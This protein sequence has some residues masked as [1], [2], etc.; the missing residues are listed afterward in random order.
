MTTWYCGECGYEFDASP[1][2]DEES[3]PECGTILYNDSLLCKTILTD[4]E[5]EV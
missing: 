1:F 4:A 5:Y 2:S 3:C